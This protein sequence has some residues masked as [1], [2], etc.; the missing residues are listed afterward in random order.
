MTPA[1]NSSKQDTEIGHY[2][3]FEAK[4]LERWLFKRTCC[5]YRGPELDSQHPHSGSQ[6]SIPLITRDPLLSSVKDMGNEHSAHTY[7]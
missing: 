7:K 5:S 6:P 2:G 4:G 3:K 1:Y